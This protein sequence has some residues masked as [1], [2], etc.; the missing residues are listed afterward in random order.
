[1][2]RH[3]VQKPESELQLPRVGS[4]IS[5]STVFEVDFKR[6]KIQSEKIKDLLEQATSDEFKIIE[7]YDARWLDF[8]ESFL[9]NYEVY[10]ELAEPDV[11]E[12]DIN[13]LFQQ[14]D[15]EL[16]NIK[17]AIESWITGNRP[18]PMT[19]HRPAPS[20]RSVCS[21]RSGGASILS[22]KIA[23]EQ[24]KAE[25]HARSARMRKRHELER[26]KLALK[27]Q[28]EE[29]EIDTELAI[30]EARTGVLDEMQQSGPV[31]QIS[32]HSDELGYKQHVVDEL[33]VSKNVCSN[34][35][36]NNVFVPKL[37][38][39]APEYI[40]GASNCNNQNAECFAFQQGNSQDIKSIVQH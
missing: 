37:N 22:A 32:V 1:M 2:K 18:K 25:L 31:H 6:I 33:E 19:E 36:D 12:E 27:M 24:K 20:V 38:V 34:N 14:R 28:E 3:G 39:N 30:A 21:A 29:L 8:Y 35:N 17:A 40:P 23:E 5:I 11:V 15:E 16:R 9:R 4:I 26:A 7:G 10:V 13:E